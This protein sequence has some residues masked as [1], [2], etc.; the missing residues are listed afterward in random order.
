MNYL[1]QELNDIKV[2]TYHYAELLSALE[3][4][5]VDGSQK[6]IETLIDEANT[7]LQRQYFN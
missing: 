4:R 1:H 5:D 6:A 3:R 7:L 2:S